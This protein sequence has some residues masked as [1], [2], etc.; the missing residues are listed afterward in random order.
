MLKKFFCVFL[1]ICLIFTP[2]ITA[3]AYEPAGI[4]ITAKSA[5]LVSMDTDEVLFEKSTEKPHYAK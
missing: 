5:L 4:E 1:I 2:S 3:N